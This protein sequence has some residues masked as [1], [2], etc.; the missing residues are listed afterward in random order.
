MTNTINRTGQ[1]SYNAVF[2]TGD[3]KQIKRGSRLFAAAYLVIVEFPAPPVS[4][5]I[6]HWTQ[7]AGTRS[8]MGFARDR[9]A[10]FKAIPRETN[11]LIGKG[12]FG[13]SMKNPGKIIHEEVIDV[14]PQ[15]NL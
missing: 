14:T 10:A 11:H 7:P 5:D 15:H 12:R 3:S 13:R 8:I 2:S 6:N 4:S 1:Y 9:D